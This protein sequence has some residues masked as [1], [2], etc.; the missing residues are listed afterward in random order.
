[1]AEP[2]CNTSHKTCRECGEMKPVAAF[3]HNRR[4]C[5]VCRAAYMQGWKNGIRI[6][7]LHPIINGTH[8]ACSKCGELKPLDAYRTIK[9]REA[10]RAECKACAADYDHVYHETNPGVRSALWDNYYHTHHADMLSRAQNYYYDNQKERMAYHQAWSKAN[11]EKA[12]A[13]SRK[14]KTAKRGLPS[15]FTDAER[16]F[17]RQYFHYACA[18]CGKEEGFQWII[19]LDHWIPLESLPVLAPSR[20]T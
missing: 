4:L 7:P 14:R 19:G 6:G 10:R 17:C 1:M 13:H 3:P 15:T 16:A 5:R 11:P 9:R 8:K 20:T 12:N 2:T 18:I